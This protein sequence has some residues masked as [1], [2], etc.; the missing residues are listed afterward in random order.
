MQVIEFL[1]DHPIVFLGASA[2]LVVV[3]LLNVIFGRRFRRKFWWGLCCFASFTWQFQ[4]GDVTTL[5]AFPVGS[6]VVLAVALLGPR[7]K[8]K[9]RALTADGSK[10]VPD[11]WW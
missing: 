10:D 7:P 4:T 6:M 3:S 1:L 8:P 11:G 9:E 5:V 2:A